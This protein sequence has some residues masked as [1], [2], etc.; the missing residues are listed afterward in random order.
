MIC[1]DL[2]GSRWV[3]VSTPSQVSWGLSHHQRSPGGPEVKRSHSCWSTTWPG[4]I[5]GMTGSCVATACVKAE[6]KWDRSQDPAFHE[7]GNLHFQLPRL[8]LTGSK[9]TSSCHILLV[10]TSTGTAQDLCRE[11]ISPPSWCESDVCTYR[12]SG[13]S[14]WK[15]SFG[16][17]C[18]YTRF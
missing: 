2:T 4:L 3:V 1:L 9:S 15:L 16:N 13:I 14:C 18:P 5:I 11:K 10:K 12:R 8:R 7:E 17:H 6:L